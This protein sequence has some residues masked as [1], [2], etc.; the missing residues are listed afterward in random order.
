MSG[1]KERVFLTG[2]P[3][4]GT[5]LLQ[6][7]L[8]A[9]SQ[10]ASF[11]ETHFFA[12]IPARRPW[13]RTLGFASRGAGPAFEQLLDYID[14]HEARP[15]SHGHLF[16]RPYAQMY[17]EVLDCLTLR[18][19]KSLWLEKT[20]RH[21]LYIDCIQRQV[22]GA[23]FIHI[24]RS[25]ADTVASLY[26]VT[27]QHPEVWS[28]PCSIDR[29]V[30][31]WIKYM[32]IARTYLFKTGHILV[33]YE[34]LVENPRVMLSRLCT[35]LNVDFEEG[36]LQH[37]PIAAQQLTYQ[38]EVWKGSVQSAIQGA[39]TTKFQRLFD[40]QQRQYILK[41]LSVVDMDDFG[42]TH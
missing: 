7:L 42:G 29:C 34:Q 11:P 39:D 31:N 20:P 15:R 12:H 26:E 41:Q 36:M 19:G 22:P 1:L 23:K 40:E 10:I 18:Q 38:A 16:T 3:R 9:H 28:G 25:G 30:Q 4:S 32:Q 5:T 24:V 13:L 14:Y 8:A 17:V 33:R 27:H 2:C 35:F 6:S 37:Y 21:A